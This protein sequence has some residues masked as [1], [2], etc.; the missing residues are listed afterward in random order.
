MRAR[1]RLSQAAGFP[2]TVGVALLA[3]G[4][5][6]LYW[7]GRNMAAMM[8]T[9]RAFFAQPWRLLTSTLLHGDAFHL[10]FNVYWLWVFGSLLESELGAAWLLGLMVAFAGIS[11]A[12]QFALD[13][14]GIGLSGVGYGL[15]GFLW[16]AERRDAR[17]AGAMDRKTT[18]LFA[19]WFVLC[20]VLTWAKV[21]QI[22]NVAHGVGALAGVMASVAITGSG[23]R[24]RQLPKAA[25]WIGLSVLLAV[26]VLF[27]TSLRAQVN[28][29]EDAGWDEAARAYDLL[30]EEK[31]AEAVALYERAVK[32]GPK[33]ASWWF[34]LAIGYQRQG[35]L[36]DARRAYQ[37]AAQL[38]PDDATFIAAAAMIPE[39]V[40]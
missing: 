32:L 12:A 16:G 19:A 1:A 33:H 37:R 21:W 3:I 14:A 34:N 5:T 7:S 10:T 36:G 30:G 22:A 4:A 23:N 8:V 40:K 35:R 38:K 29:N 24:T 11:G 28:L 17:F 31:N 6:L 13:G 2:I 27:A 18:Q 15:L 25:G 9:E 39:G 26:S 20:I